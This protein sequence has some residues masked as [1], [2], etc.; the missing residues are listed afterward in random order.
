MGG[1]VVNREAWNSR[2]KGAK[3]AK[4]LAA[5]RTVFYVQPLIAR[6]RF[7]VISSLRQRFNVK[8]FANMRGV[9]SHGFS[10]EYPS[11]DEFVETPITTIPRTRAKFQ[12]GIASRIFFERPAAVFIFADVTYVSLWLSLA[13]GRLM[14]VPIVV[15]GQ[16]LYR[17]PKPGFFRSISYRAVVAMSSRYVCYGESSRKSLERIGC[18]KRNLD[19][20]HN[21]LLVETTINPFEKTGDEP[22]VLFVGRL[23]DGCNVEILIRAVES[24]VSEGHKIVLHIIGDGELRASMQQAYAG[25]AHVIWHGAVYDDSEIAN[26]SR[27]CRIGC[28]PGA[29]GLSVVHMFGL[30]L[31]PLIHDQ[32]H[33]HMGPEPEYVSPFETGFLYARDGGVEALAAVLRSVWDLPPAVIRKIGKRAF[34][35]YRQLNSPTLGERLAQIVDNVVNK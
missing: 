30:S 31:P 32:L 33:M 18:R 7:E 6:Y 28:Y 26:I 25:R 21:S 16:G 35:K 22:G 17:Y 12:H 10:S 4:P 19:A 24:L 3:S 11:C 23:R 2:V 15:H 1:N 27:A 5:K 13:L 8:V 9:E 34:S 20:A 29:A 14:R